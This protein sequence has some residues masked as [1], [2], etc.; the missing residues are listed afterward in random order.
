M[1]FLALTFPR[2]I[3]MGAQ[4]TADWSTTVNRTFGGWA[5]RN[6]NR[7]R[8]IHAWDVGFAV[9][10]AADYEAIVQHFHQARGQAH[11]WPFED[12]LDHAATALE[13]VCTLI[14]GSVYQLYKRYGSTNAF[15]RKITR[16]RTGAVVVYR[17][18]EA[19]TT[20][21][22]PAINYT[23]G[24]ITVSGHIAGDVYTWAGTFDVPCRYATDSLPGLIIDRN[25][26]AAGQHLVQCE[27][28]LIEED[29]E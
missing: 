4:R 24:Q 14:S 28:I 19:V 6:I 9:R 18:R 15:D 10:T 23:T 11:S 16:P 29:F 17:T 20:T 5:Q 3:G 12:K 2:R 25:P 8:A 13:G 7:S 27:S 1:S 22:S 21:I 26:G